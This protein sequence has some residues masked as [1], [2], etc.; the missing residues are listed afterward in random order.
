MTY[1]FHSCH[2]APVDVHGNERPMSWPQSLETT[3]STTTLAPAGT[4]R[5]I[6]SR[7]T[8]RVSARDSTT[9]LWMTLARLWPSITIA[10]APAA[11]T[12]GIRRA[13]MSQRA[14]S[15]AE[16]KRRSVST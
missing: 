6:H 10:A 2:R 9:S 5:T 7:V 16:R 12:T 13:R 14:A 4:C 1:G 8:L 11:S 15:T 3:G